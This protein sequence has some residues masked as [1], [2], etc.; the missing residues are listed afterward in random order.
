M[1]AICK[2]FG[3]TQ[4]QLIEAQ[5][6]RAHELFASFGPAFDRPKEIANGILLLGNICDVLIRVIE[7]QQSQIDHLQ[8]IVVELAPHRAVDFM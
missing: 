8:K 1:L 7:N 4:T 3:M 2:G 5:I 6:K